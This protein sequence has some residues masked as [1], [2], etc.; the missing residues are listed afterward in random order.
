[1]IGCGDGDGG[2]RCV[3][4]GMCGDGASRDEGQWSGVVG[5]D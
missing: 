4:C 1:M 5:L 3:D 2:G